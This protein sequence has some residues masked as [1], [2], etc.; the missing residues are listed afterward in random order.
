[1]QPQLMGSVERGDH[2]E[3][4]KRSHATVQARA[5]P[6][7]A[8]AVLG[9]QFLHIDVEVGGIFYRGIDVFG[10]KHFPSRLEALIEQRLVFWRVRAGH[11]WL[12]QGNAATAAWIVSNSPS[13]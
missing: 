8:P 13:I 4:Q 10:T 11:G 2:G 5:V 7:V 9:H 12:L 6:Y 1:M 3:V